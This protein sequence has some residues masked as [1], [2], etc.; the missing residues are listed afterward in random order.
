[1]KKKEA[2]ETLLLNERRLRAVKDEQDSLSDE[3]DELWRSIFG[4]FDTIEGAGQPARFLTEEGMVLARELARHP[5]DGRVDLKTLIAKLTP[6]QWKAVSVAR[7]ERVYDEGRLN[8]AVEKGIVSIEL[9][10]S[11]VLSK[12]SVPR[13]V[14]KTCTKDEA[15]Q[16]QSQ[17]RLLRI[18]A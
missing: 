1:M 9:V 6:E 7:T 8:K 4:C 13:R 3:Y 12:A 11:C 14:H 16:L 2:R 10:E 18:V 17:G 5:Q 15:A